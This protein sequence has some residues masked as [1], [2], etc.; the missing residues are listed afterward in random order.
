M[1]I[2][3]FTVAILERLEQQTLKKIRKCEDSESTVNES[4]RGQIVISSKERL[5][6]SNHG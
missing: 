1:V 2:Q 5:P 3:I 6:V 4:A